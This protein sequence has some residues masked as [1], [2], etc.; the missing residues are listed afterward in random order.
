MFSE[1]L[2]HCPVT[3]DT[4]S[5]KK[6]NKNIFAYNVKED[7]AGINGVQQLTHMILLME[8]REMFSLESPK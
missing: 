4:H 6:I 1:A 5:L 8:R 7:L 3:C 2:K